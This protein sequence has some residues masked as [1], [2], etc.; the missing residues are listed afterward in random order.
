[1]P[2]TRA[3]TVLNCHDEVEGVS[4]LMDDMTVVCYDSLHMANFG[5]ALAVLVLLGLGL[6]FAMYWEGHHAQHHRQ[7]VFLFGTYSCA[8]S[9]CF[10]L[11]FDGILTELSLLCTHSP[12][13]CL[14]SRMGVVGSCGFAAQTYS[15]VCGSICY[16]TDFTRFFTR[17]IFILN[18]YP[19]TPEC[20][21]Y[22]C[23]NYS[24]YFSPGLLF[25]LRLVSSC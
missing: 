24:I 21:A 8:I 17:L 22:L 18:F 15:Q 19:V 25:K 1:M 16:G 2:I 20:A 3:R 14:P 9:F 4:Y 10:V 23:H 11:R 13:R 6:P 5:G 7:L 12:S